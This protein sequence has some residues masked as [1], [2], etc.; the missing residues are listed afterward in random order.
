[1]QKFEG[2]A[3]LK[4]EMYSLLKKPFQNIYPHYRECLAARRLVKFRE[5]TPITPKV[6]RVN[7]LNFKPKLS[8]R[9]YSPKPW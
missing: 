2:P 7:T 8:V 6:I 9:P 3:P 5:L 1:M 4:A